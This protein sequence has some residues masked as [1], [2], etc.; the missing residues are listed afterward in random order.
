MD[1]SSAPALALW[2]RKCA[3]ATDALTE[4]VQSGRVPRATHATGIKMEMLIQAIRQSLTKLGVLTAHP[5]AFGIVATY[6]LLWFLFQPGTLDWHAVATLS[7]WF[8]ILLIQRAEHR[9]TQ[10]IHAKLDELLAANAGARSEFK[11]LD[12]EEP[13]DIERTRGGG[14]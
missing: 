9:D 7:T 8:M 11:K 2:P 13:E 12:E 6:A 3:A 10:A 5:L 14:N 1:F 4:K